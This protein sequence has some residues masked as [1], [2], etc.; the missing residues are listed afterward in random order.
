MY[1]CT[2]NL[3]YILVSSSSQSGCV[4]V[5]NATASIALVQVG[6]DYM[7]ACILLL[8]ATELHVGVKDIWEGLL[9]SPDYHAH[10]DMTKVQIDVGFTWNTLQISMHRATTKCMF[11]IAQRMYEFIMQQKKRTERTIGLMLPAGT[12]VS[13]AFAAY[14]EEQKRAEETRAASNG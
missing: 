2:I 7:S 13:S 10:Q 9:R 8:R 1:H 6:V 5:H 3:F 4:P 14:Q 12:E 11:G